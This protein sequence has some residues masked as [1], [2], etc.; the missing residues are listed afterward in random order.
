[1]GEPERAARAAFALAALLFVAWLPRE[2]SGPEPS[3][4]QSP[5]ERAAL[6]D[7]TREVACGTG[8]AGLPEL[9]GPARR[10]FALPLDLNHADAATLETLP[11]IGP[12]RA[13]AIVRERE[14]RPFA[15]PAEVVRVRGIGPVVAAGLAGLVAVEPR[16]QNQ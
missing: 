1:M 10:L 3:H 4:C 15:S 12:V 14:R 6:A 7:W 11:G 5:V 9:R 2:S 8:A 16:R 13:E